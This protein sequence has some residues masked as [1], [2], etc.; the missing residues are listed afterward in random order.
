MPIPQDSEHSQDAYPT[1]LYS[2]LPIPYSLSPIP[3]SLP[4]TSSPQVPPTSAPPH[5]EIVDET[6][7][8]CAARMPKAS[9]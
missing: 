8:L 1:R 9:R 5:Q 3:Y 4:P 7:A 6:P 2:L